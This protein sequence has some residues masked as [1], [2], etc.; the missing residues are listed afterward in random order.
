MNSVNWL[1]LPFEYP[2]LFHYHY[3]LHY[4]K[5]PAIT[6][7]NDDVDVGTKSTPLESKEDSQMNS[8]SP[9]T[10][11]LGEYKLGKTIGQGAFSKV[12]LAVHNETG[13]KVQRSHPS[14]MLMI[15]VCHKNH[16]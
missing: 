1:Q 4:Q 16:R 5:Y 15:L 6:F 11:T 12:K 7:Y 10:T 9:T 2:Y 14:E 13:Q 3:L 8:F